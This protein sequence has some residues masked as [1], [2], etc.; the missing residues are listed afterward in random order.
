[1]A[2]GGRHR[3]LWN[4]QVYIVYKPNK[5]VAKYYSKLFVL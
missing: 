1:M 4:R 2:V 3:T 5:I